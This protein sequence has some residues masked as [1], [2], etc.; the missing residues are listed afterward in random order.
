MRTT[1]R[2]LIPVL[3]T[4]C[5]LASLATGARVQPAGGNTSGA[6]FGTKLVAGLK[7]TP[8]CLDAVA[9]RL[10]TG[11]LTIMAWFENRDA[12]MNWYNSPQHR[13]LIM[14][15]GVTPS[16]EPMAHID[17]EAPIMV[18]A[19]VRLAEDGSTIGRGLPFSE[20]SIELYTPMPGGAM[21]NGRLTPKGVHVPHMRGADGYQVP[22]K[23]APKDHD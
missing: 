5:V 13:R 14:G 1:P 19:T 9:A 22:A 8:G 6:D 12:A 15:S 18:M 21:F 23:D 2:R 10:T 17:R 16:D 3:L 4:A 7:G 11:Q 20:I